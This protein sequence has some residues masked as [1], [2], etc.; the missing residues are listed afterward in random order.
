MGRVFSLQTL[1]NFLNYNKMS[2]KNTDERPLP[3]IPSNWKDLKDEDLMYLPPPAPFFQQE[4]VKEKM[5]RKTKENPFV[6][7][8]CLFTAAVLVRGLWTLK[9]GETKKTQLF[10]RL[11]IAGQ[12]F[13][14][15]AMVGGAL[16]NVKKLNSN[17]PS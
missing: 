11:R 15:A 10:M 17:K 6:P 14:V 1:A 13:A 12:A 4:G 7:I 8:G 9:S 3:D 5:I 2:D 16:Y